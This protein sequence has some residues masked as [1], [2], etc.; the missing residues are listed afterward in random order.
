MN[1]ILNTVLKAALVLVTAIRTDTAVIAKNIKNTNET[2]ITKWVVPDEMLLKDS[3]NQNMI[4]N[5]TKFKIAA[6]EYLHKSKGLAIKNLIIPKNDIGK[7]KQMLRDKNF[8]QLCEKGSATYFYHNDGSLV[9]IFANKINRCH[10]LTKNIVYNEAETN[11]NK[12]ISP[13][14][15]AFKITKDGKLAPR[16]LWVS[17]ITSEEKKKAI[18]QKIKEETNYE[19]K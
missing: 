9:I 8:K 7:T 10:Y 11:Q 15:I 16:N 17:H 1:R 6:Y 12:L 4:L 5:N 14:N 2:V 3:F 19:I 18:K 13:R